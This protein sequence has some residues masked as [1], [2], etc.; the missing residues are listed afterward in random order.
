MTIFHASADKNDITFTKDDWIQL[1][2]KSNET[3]LARYQVYMKLGFYFI[4]KKY[5]NK[6]ISISLWYSNIFEIW[7]YRIGIVFIKYC[8]I[9]LIQRDVFVFTVWIEDIIVNDKYESGHINYFLIINI[10]YRIHNLGS[11]LALKFNG[12]DLEKGLLPASTHPGSF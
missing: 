3:I 8:W 6:L 4:S 12:K 9:V 2:C 1:H 7:M 11:K 10:P 5:S